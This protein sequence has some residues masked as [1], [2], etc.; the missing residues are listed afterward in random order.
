[1]LYG[2]PEVPRQEKE[3]I[4]RVVQVLIPNESFLQAPV[5]LFYTKEPVEYTGTK[6]GNLS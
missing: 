6:L 2:A 1:M 4:Q 3:P 5:N